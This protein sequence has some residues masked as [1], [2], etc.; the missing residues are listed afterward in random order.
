MPESTPNTAGNSR[1]TSLRALIRLAIPV[2]LAELGWM[3][4][5][6]VDVIMVGRLGPV[7]IAAVALGNAL[8]YAPSLF[9]LGLLLGLDTVIARSYGEGD[10]DVCHRWLA[11]GVYIAL[12]V[13]PAVMLVLLGLGAGAAH[14]GIKPELVAPSASYLRVLLWGTLPL[15]LYT[16]ARRYLQAVDQA[17]VITWTFVASNLTNWGLNYLLI[18]G[19]LGLP[20]MGVRGSALSTVLSRVLMVV[21]LFGF[22]WRHERSRGHPLFAHWA[23]PHLADIRHLLR[24]GT[25]VALQLLLEIGAFAFAT[26][27]AGRISADALAAH[28]IALNY[29]ALAFMVPLGISAAAAVSVGHALGAGDPIGARR[30]AWQAL[31]LGTGFMLCSATVFLT[32]PRLLTALYTHDPRVTA[33]TVPLLA[34]SALFAVFDAVQIILSGALRGMALT[35]VP[36]LANL[37]GYWATG[38]PLGV[39]LAF[40]WHHPPL[41]GVIGIWT[42]LT[43]AL[44]IV[45]TILFLYWQQQSSRLAA[46]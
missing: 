33:L 15:L 10:F 20:A 42:G 14:F 24:L 9:G 22:A 41:T 28:Q 23:A 44:I 40:H 8:Y 37:F 5:S 17:A 39:L 6:V 36:M 38:L 1:S 35:R 19:K 3:L 13:A 4:Q 16:A 46:Q 2:V 32:A 26:V 43:T 7:A 25:P 29:A 31:A 21:M 45:A 34:L 18:N 30:S 27:L 11:Q 12:V